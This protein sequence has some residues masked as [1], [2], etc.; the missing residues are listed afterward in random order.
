MLTVLRDPSLY[1]DLLQTVKRS[2]PTFQTNLFALPDQLEAWVRDGSLAYA[3]FPGAVLLFRQ[4][5]GASH[6]YHLAADDQALTRALQGLRPSASLQPLVTELVGKELDLEGVTG[7]YLRSGFQHH[8][9]LCRM[10]A[11]P[12]DPKEDPQESSVE[13]AGVEDA[14]ALQSFLDRFLDPLA[15]QPPTVADL[16]AAARRGEAFQVKKQGTLAGV[17]VMGL[18]GRTAL[19]RY[20]FVDPQFHGQGIGSHLI[21]RFFQANRHCVRLVL[22]VLSDNPSALAKYAH[23]G[24]RAD[25]LHDR[26]MRFVTQA[27]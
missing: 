14:P 8:R 26:V 10:V 17:L 6:L 2:A 13:Q 24:F 1:Y 15:E 19:L 20:W 25:G 5:R 3:A 21:G 27:S 16:E 11:K 22:W 12:R 9:T 18:A 7:C 23:Y 4:G